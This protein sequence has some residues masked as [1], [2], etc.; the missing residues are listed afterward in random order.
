MTRATAAAVLLLTALPALPAGA[1]EI[2][3]SALVSAGTTDVDG[4][5]TESVDQQYGFTLFQRLSPYLSLRA[6][7]SVLD[8]SSEAPGGEDFSRRS[9][10]PRVELLYARPAVSARV[11]YS[12]RVSAGSTP[13]DEFE[14]RSFL[15][16][17]SWRTP[18][19]PALSLQLRDESNVADVALFGRDTDSTTIT[20]AA[21]WSRAFWSTGY[22]VERFELDNRLNGLTL[23]QTRHDLRFDAG[24]SFFDKRFD[25]AFASRVSRLDR[26]EVVPGGADLAEPVPARQGLFAVD[27]SPD[28]GTLEPAPGL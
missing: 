14:V 6:G 16:S 17:L 28:V 26:S 8:L 27:T 2:S 12:D 19:G 13:A 15:G 7:A 20:A 25:L 21:V 10:E 23:E 5:E 9:R 24:R 3:G 22:T 11:S 1:V 18:W 4:Q